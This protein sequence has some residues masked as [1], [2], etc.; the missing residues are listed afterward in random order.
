MSRYDSAFGGGKGSAAKAKRA[1]ASQYGA[2]K[3]EKIF[4]ATKNKRRGKHK[5]TAGKQGD[6]LKPKRG[7]Y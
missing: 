1:M 5:M 7:G 6:A 4:Y 2:K 3:G